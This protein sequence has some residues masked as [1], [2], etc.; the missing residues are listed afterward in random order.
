MFIQCQPNAATLLCEADN[1]S[2]FKIVA[3]SAPANGS[4]DWWPADLGT[5]TEDGAHAWVSVPGFLARFEADQT[6]GWRAGF[7]RMIEAAAKYGFLDTE[8]NAFRAH[9]ETI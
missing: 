3:P 9:I 8:K 7:D 6:E 4:A 5:L 2:Q 1:F